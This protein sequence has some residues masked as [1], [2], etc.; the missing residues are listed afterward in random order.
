M[1]TFYALLDR[2]QRITIL[3]ESLDL[4]KE[5]QIKMYH[6]D[7]NLYNEFTGDTENHITLDT[8]IKDFLKTIPKHCSI[9][10]MYLPESE[11]YYQPC[12]IELEE[13]DT[14]ISNFTSHY[15]SLLTN[16]EDV[17]EKAKEL[18]SE[19]GTNS[20]FK[21]DYVVFSRDKENNDMY[22]ITDHI[23]IE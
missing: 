10:T 12:F 23:T 8:K 16:I 3:S 1:K 20:I 21:G 19:F 18:Q 4:I 2:L 17:K 6:A 11:E 9:I 15:G 22:I 5:E 7:S 14:A 13:N